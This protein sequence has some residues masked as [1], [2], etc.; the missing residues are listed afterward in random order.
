MLLPRPTLRRLSRLILH[1]YTLFARYHVLAD[2]ETEVFLGTKTMQ[3][4]GPAQTIDGVRVS[5]GDEGIVIC[6]KAERKANGL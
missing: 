1:G 5:L 3:I 6:A 4:G 2:S